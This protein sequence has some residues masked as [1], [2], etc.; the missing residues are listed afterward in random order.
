MT[1]F[2][3][4]AHPKRHDALRM[5]FQIRQKVSLAH[6]VHTGTTLTVKEPVS[7]PKS[8]SQELTNNQ[9]WSSLRGTSD[10]PNSTGNSEHSESY[11]LNRLAQQ[12]VIHLWISLS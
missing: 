6:Q 10:R 11:S 7:D 3:L 12:E 2:Q 9:E 5:M 4:F 1:D 8:D